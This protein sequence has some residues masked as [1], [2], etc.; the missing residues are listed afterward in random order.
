MSHLPL[1]LSASTAIRIRSAIPAS[2]YK[3]HSLPAGKSGRFDSS[4]SV[5]F[6]S[7]VGKASV[8]GVSPA[9]SLLSF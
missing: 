1:L 5:S 9:F 8:L 2:K 6:P 7:F 3:Y 4:L